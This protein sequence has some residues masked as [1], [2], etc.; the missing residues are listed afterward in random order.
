MRKENKFLQQ[1]ELLPF[2]IIQAAV[3]GNIMAIDTVLKH[4]EGYIISLSTRRLYDKN[5]H[6]FYCVDESL[7]RRLEIKLITKILEFEII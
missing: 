6:S 2:S 1:I 3:S 5:G 7:K 4:Y